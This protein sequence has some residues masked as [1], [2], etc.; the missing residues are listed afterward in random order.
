MI[1]SGKYLRL[2]DQDGKEWMHLP[3]GDVSSL[4]TELMYTIDYRPEQHPDYA[5]LK[6]ALDAFLSTT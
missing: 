1:L 6:F 4:S 3:C 2:V 5:D